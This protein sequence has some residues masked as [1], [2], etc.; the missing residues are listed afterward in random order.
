MSSYSIDWSPLLPWP[1]VIAA[2]I[3]CA[4]VVLLVLV[5]RQRAGWVRAIGVAL[6][7][8]A[9][10]NP[11]L[12]SE[13]RE[14]LNDVVA[15][16]V[17]RSGSQRLADRTAQTDA[18]RAAVESQLKARPFTDLRL[19]DV[20]ERDSDQDG[21]RLFDALGNGLADVPPNR[22]A[23]V[24]AITDGQVHDVPA[25]LR[26][27]GIGAPFHALITGRAE[28]RD[29]RVEIVQAPRFGIV[30]KD[31]EVSVRV[32]DVNGTSGTARLT[33]R[34]DGQRIAERT[35]AVGD[36][37]RL[38]VRIEHG[39]PNI[40]E[41]E[42]DGLPGELT[43]LNNVA[44]L[45]VEGVRDKLRVLLVSGEPHAGERTWR[46]LLKSDANVELVHFTIL[47]PMEKQDATPTNE[48]SLIAFPTRELFVQKINEFDLIIF[49]RYSNQTILPSLYFENI[50]K[51]VRDG[52]AVLL[53]A[54]G[55]FAQPGGLHTTPLMG[56]LPAR[57]QGRTIE[58]A[59]LPRVSDIGQRHPV[60]RAL[61]GDGNPPQWS[62][63][64]RLVQAQPLKGTTVMTGAEDRPLLLL[65]REQ[66]G[67]VALL[68][69]D[70][71]WLWARGFGEGGP[72]LDLLR[73]LAHWLMKE[74]ELEEEALRLRSAGNTLTIERQTLG[75]RVD[76]I[77]LMGPDGESF[78]LTLQPAAPGLWRANFTA[79]KPGLYRAVDQERVAFANV[80]PA[81][82]REFRDVASTTDVLAP[83]AAES[84]G[85]ARRVQ[86]AG[87]LV[88]PRIIDVSTGPRYYGNDTIGLKPSEA[89]VV[90]GIGL[91]PIA[92]G[93]AGLLLLLG[94]A[95]WTWL[96][97]GSRR[98]RPRG[99]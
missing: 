96:A 33:I 75:E 32:L 41:L 8:A 40:I 91:F 70:H 67:R 49:D 59:F 84:G 22:V 81:N 57:P 61:P 5:T 98:L 48:L 20:E 52:G 11:T 39:G 44:V 14:K 30:G 56:V 37:A 66:K 28:E 74:P 68:L 18:V 93:A 24:I 3:A 45:P 72:Y 50:A 62:P 90:R 65:H 16:L 7:L 55:E 83:L 35:V 23:G 46:N 9:L 36:A 54:G 78:T 21:T 58:G 69:S 73:R 88:V 42:A 79:R 19:I 92:A 82:P 85:S 13:D 17:D 63:W 53:A 10:F 26:A 80:G 94:A 34:R 51:Y 95:L 43:M 71:A 1:L 76:D 89:H 86:V 60:T 4:V 29:R 47:R 25:S 2:A 64:F 27:L 38:S 97:E 87:S 6:I 31:V 77:R 12:T 99:G 15:V